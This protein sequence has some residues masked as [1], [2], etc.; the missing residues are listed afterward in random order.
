MANYPLPPESVLFNFSFHT[1]TSNR[2]NSIESG[3]GGGGVKKNTLKFVRKKYQ[4]SQPILQLSIANLQLCWRL[5]ELF[6]SIIKYSRFGLSVQW[7]NSNALLQRLIDH[8]ARQNC[9][10]CYTKFTVLLT[11]QKHCFL[12]F[13]REINAK[14]KS[15]SFFFFYFHQ[16]VSCK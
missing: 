6:L 1:Q 10:R 7:L 16:R 14:R 4:M 15:K 11:R 2:M 5:T 3:E 13:C 8:V 9:T 12:V